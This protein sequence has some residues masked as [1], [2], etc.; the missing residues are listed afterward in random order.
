[1]SNMNRNTLENR[2][3]SSEGVSVSPLVL[4]VALQNVA[5]QNVAL[6]DVASLLLLLPAA[7]LPLLGSV[8]GSG[9]PAG[10]PSSA[11]LKHRKKKKSLE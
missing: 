10:A 9:K 5:L 1:M 8:E 7:H 2:V 6:P 11:C 3:P 4:I